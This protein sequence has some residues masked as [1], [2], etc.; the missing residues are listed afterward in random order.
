MR[1]YRDG[2]KMITRAGL[3]PELSIEASVLNG[4]SDVWNLNVSLSGKICDGSRQLQ[5]AV[6]S[7]CGQ[8]ELS[9]C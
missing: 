1:F 5:D 2:I 7:S 8:I 6:V 9:N 4:F 3:T